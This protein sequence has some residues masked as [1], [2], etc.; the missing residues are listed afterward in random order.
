MTDRV[1]FTQ[2]GS[3]ACGSMIVRSGT[4]MLTE[5]QCREAERHGWERAD[6]PFVINTDPP[7]YMM[8]RT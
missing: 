7:K 2:D 6:P 5:E 1:T 3:I 4:V 8:R